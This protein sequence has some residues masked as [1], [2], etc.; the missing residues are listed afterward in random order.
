MFSLSFFTYKLAQIKNF[1]EWKLAYLERKRITE[2]EIKISF[3][4]N[5]FNQMGK[6]ISIS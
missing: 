5:I 2:N 6:T 3:E 1:I 4:I